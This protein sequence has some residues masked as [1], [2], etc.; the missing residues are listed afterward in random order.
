LSPALEVVSPSFIIR[1]N[2]KAITPAHLYKAFQDAMDARNFNEFNFADAFTTWELQ[3]GYPVINVILDKAARQIQITQKRYL[4]EDSNNID[5]SSWLIPLNFAHA[6]NSD[7][8]DTTIT[9]YFERGAAVKAI[10]TETIQGFDSDDWFVFNKQQLGFYRVNYDLDNWRNII[11]VLNSADYER[12]HVLNRAQLVDDVLNF[13]MDGHIGFDIALGVMT[14]LQRETEYL[15][16]AAAANYLDRLDY[17]LLG[18][19]TRGL[20]HEFVNHL[21]SRMYARRSLQQRT[22]DDILTKYSREFAINW[23]CRTGSARCLSDAYTEIDRAVGGE[24]SIPKPL[25][26]VF[27]CNGIKG[28]SKQHVFVHFW[29]K[30]SASTDQADRLRYIDGLACATDPELVKSFLD[31]SSGY[32]SDVNYHVHERLRIFNAVLTSSSIGIPS[33]LDFLSG[34]IFEIA[35]T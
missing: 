28:S 33:A 4:N 23:S 7:F 19:A 18:D 5:T 20:L 11:R 24:K 35:A 6:A 30:M 2:H 10:P 12:I 29:R 13:A 3:R 9:H 31:S 8:N 15:P 14:Y 1:R 27:L 32:N 17:L 21:V 22:G 34:N 25:E 16:W 26:V